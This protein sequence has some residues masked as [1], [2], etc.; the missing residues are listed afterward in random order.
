MSY[1]VSIRGW[2]GNYTSNLG[3]FF[4]RFICEAGPNGRGGIPGLHQLTGRQAADRIARSLAH[5]AAVEKD[6]TL[7]RYDAENG[8][9]DHKGAIR[10]LR[11]IKAACEAAPRC[12]V[13]VDW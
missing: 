9:G 8:W 13:H 2:S 4:Y 3:P 1:D 12:R 6:E 5:V 7:S 10:F 11:E